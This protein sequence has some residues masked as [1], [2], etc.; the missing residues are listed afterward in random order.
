MH[1]KKGFSLIELLIVIAIILVIAAIAIPN[2][3]RARISA[4]EASATGSL[5]AIKTAEAGYYG[6]YPTVGFSA[7]LANLGGAPPCAASAATG[8]LIDNFLATAIPGS[9][10]KSGYFFGE[11]G[12]A[13]GALNSSYVAG[14]IP[15]NFS[16]SGFRLF[17]ETDDGVIRASTA[18]GAIPATTAACYAYPLVQ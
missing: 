8:C 18:A 1:D 10:G 2:L 9:A 4:N 7:A 12:L 5:Q 13:S 16:Q 15:V 17:C 3:L 14:A 11:T 6:A